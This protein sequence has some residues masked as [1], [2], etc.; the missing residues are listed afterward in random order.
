MDADVLHDRRRWLQHSF[1]GQALAV[2]SPWSKP[3]AA[4]DANRCDRA[5]SARSGGSWSSGQDMLLIP[6]PTDPARL[7]AIRH[8]CV[9]PQLGCRVLLAFGLNVCKSRT[10][11]LR[12]REFCRTSFVLGAKSSCVAAD[13][14]CWLWQVVHAETNVRVTI[15]KESAWS[16]KKSQAQARAA[17]FPALL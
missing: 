1:Q 17:D 5:V 3:H 14:L 10:S 7:Q 16:S 9:Q 8:I 15:S 2:P 12:R 13:L 11:Q 6:L 4:E